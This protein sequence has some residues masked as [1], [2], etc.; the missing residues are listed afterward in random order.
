MKRTT[1]GILAV[2]LAGLAAALASAAPASAGLIRPAGRAAW[3]ARVQAAPVVARHVIVIGIPG[4]TWNDVSNT[5]AMRRLAAAGSVGSLA[6]TTI[7]K[8][9]C[10]ADAWLT[11]N[12]GTRAAADPVAAPA[13]PPIPP[14]TRLHAPAGRPGTP[15]PPS[16][17]LPE[18]PSYV[19][20]NAQTG[21]NP[22]W[23]TLARAPGTAGGSGGCAAGF[24]TG[25]SLALADRAG[26][27]AH[28]S[29][30]IPQASQL[31]SVLSQCRLTV[32]GLG[33]LSQDGFARSRD[34]EV[35]NWLVGDIT[36]A[37]PGG[38][39]IML[40]GLGDDGTAQLRAIIVA[41][42]G[43][44]HGLLTSSATRQ[45][46][47]VTITDLTPSVLTWLGA[48][49]P[50]ALTGA[51]VTAGS[52]GPLAGVIK[53]MI[54]QETADQVYKSIVGWF[55]LY[56]GIAEAVVFLAIA[57]LLRG[58]GASRVRRRVAWYTAAGAFG[59]AVPAGTF[60]AGLLP[61]AQWPHPALWLYG[62]GL[63][64]AAVIAVPAAAGPWRRNPF[65]PPGF[66]CAVTLA[67][68]GIDVMTGSRLQLGAPFGLSVVEA[69]RFYGIG[70]NALG[71]YATA[72]M[73]TAAWAAAA[74]LARAGSGTAA[75][76]R[77]AAAA[78]GAV[79]AAAVVVSGWPGFGAK[80]GGTIAMVP[81]FCL[82]VAAAGGVRITPRRAVV[83]AASG[84]VV[85]AAF[86]VLN[87]L[88]IGPLSHQG[89]FV[90][91]LIA[92][93]AG[94]T[95]NRKISSNLR[96]VT[97]T[98][99]TLIPPVVALGAGLLLAWPG[100]LRQR[101][102]VI[103][104]GRCPLVRT[105]LVAVWL[106]AVLSWFL[107]DSGVSVVAAALPVALPLGILLS[108]RTANQPDLAVADDTGRRPGP[109]PRAGAVGP[110][111]TAG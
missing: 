86:A 56:Y 37:A 109:A 55:F 50:A 107:E 96:S 67:V 80:V 73:F 104:I 90:R 85:V 43:Y 21:Y 94:G 30:S 74:V 102:F 25:A 13:C 84:V 99:Y 4:L 68:I 97:L 47:I 58:T 22:A 3:S 9:T 57:L 111:S 41:G 89:D 28:Y 16:A 92:G 46:G 26:R 78:A 39:I 38:S 76:R 52:R 81:A 6:V 45:P 33:A 91:Q 98:W 69:G 14:V 44:R 63:A 7:S 15:R 24:G 49:V 70:N 17:L 8:V 72:G 27:I 75:A 83:I 62:I 35:E 1:A 18:M 66:V 5:P 61:W 36:R 79:A 108:I 105:T 29:P 88:G 59:A 20:R 42:P 106:V 71:V 77:R 10:P 53:T 95:L 60:L 93:N 48:P 12:S 23:G 32:F 65:G 101:T 103:A 2:I 110:Q 87:Y 31:P 11:L 82:L 51:P 40:A 19:V 34:L 64:W 100:R 54:G